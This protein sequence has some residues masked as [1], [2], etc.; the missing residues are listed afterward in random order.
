MSDM[1]TAADATP[2]QKAPV[3]QAIPVDKIRPS[4]HQTRRNFDPEK[5]KGLA[6]SMKQE[7]Q[8]QP[9]I[10]RPAP[11]SQVPDTSNGGKNE[12]VSSDLV[13]ETYELI[14]GE[15]RWRAA[16]LLGWTIIEAKIITTISEAEAAAKGLVENTQRERLDPLEEA[17]GFS[18]LN[19][20][21]SDYWTQEKIADVFGKSQEY[22]SLSIKMLNLPEGIHE[23]IRRRIISRSHA[24]ELLPLPNQDE[25]L[26][27]ANE[28]TAKGLSHKEARKL[29]SGMLGR[30]PKD[31]GGGGA[32]T[33]A[34]SH[35][36]VK[37]KDP[38]ASLWAALPQ[39]S[40]AILVPEHGIRYK[41]GLVW[42]FDVE[43]SGVDL[44]HDPAVVARDLQSRL[45]QSLIDLGETLK[46]TA[47]QVAPTAESV[48]APNPGNSN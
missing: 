21:D 34:P 17:R 24:L 32:G 1:P 16:I 33:D 18:D 23:I 39:D 10:V 11:S 8:L 27:A 28:I 2:A 31:Q 40:A 48:E 45:A 26:A 41:G 38:L 22:V 5:L 4:A 13:A 7:G 20:L 42:S 19:R 3:V 15:R 25:Q 36:K 30:L 43:A 35:P 9:I 6:E 37:G 44:S 12:L 29:V 46:R 14:L 47:P